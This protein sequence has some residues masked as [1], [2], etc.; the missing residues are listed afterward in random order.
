M[1]ALNEDAIEQNLIELLINQGYH[2]FHRSSLVPNSDNPQRVELDS[3][4][5]ENHFKSSLEKLNPDLP[6]TAL[7]ETYQQVL[8]LGS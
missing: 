8:S 2:Y 1:P 5:L 3:V 7:M 6:D 4:V